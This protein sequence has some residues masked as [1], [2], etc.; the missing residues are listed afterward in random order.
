MLASLLLWAAVITADVCPGDATQP[1][2]V[3]NQAIIEKFVGAVFHLSWACPPPNCPQLPTVYEVE[4]VESKTIEGDNKP[5]R[6]RVHTQVPATQLNYDWTPTKAGL[7]YA[8]I[9]ACVGTDGSNCSIWTNSWDHT[10]A[11]PTLWP[12]GFLMR[13]TLPAATDGGVH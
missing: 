8:R 4:I 9:R 7:Y 6:V 1:C 12:R 10:Q 3:R 2:V 11:D 5:E 13:V